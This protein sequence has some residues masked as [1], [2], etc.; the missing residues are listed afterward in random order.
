MGVLTHPDARRLIRSERATAMVFEDRQ[1]R[2]LLERLHQ[3]A[4]VKPVC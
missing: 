4:P 1:S 3:I 2:E